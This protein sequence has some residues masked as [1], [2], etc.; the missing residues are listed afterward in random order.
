MKTI[1]L[2]FGLLVV[3]FGK[4]VAQEQERVVDNPEIQK[5]LALSETIQSGKISFVV[6]EKRKGKKGKSVT[7]LKEYKV[8]FFKTGKMIN[9]YYVDFQYNLLNVTDSMQYVYNGKTWY[10]IDHKKKICEID[11]IYCKVTCLYPFIYPIVL[12]NEM[13]SFYI[14]NDWILFPRNEFIEEM[15]K[16]GD[17]T[18][19]KLETSC[20]SPDGKKGKKVLFTKEYEWNINKSTLLRYC[21]AVKDDSGYSP[22]TV[23]KT[24]TLLTDASLNNEKYADAELYNGLNYAKSYKIK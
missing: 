22:K 15:R 16:T 5:L 9:F 24:E 1:Y 21:K 19:V 20:L 8:T 6:N 4:I 17:T 2:I 3:S 18:F 12:L 11:T 14:R 13:L 23:I 7:D 10:I